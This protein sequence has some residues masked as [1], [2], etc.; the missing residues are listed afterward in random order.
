MSLPAGS[1][2]INWRPD[3]AEEYTATPQPS[4]DA[5]NAFAV[6]LTACADRLCAGVELMVDNGASW[7]LPG[8]RQDDGTTVFTVGAQVTATIQARGLTGTDERTNQ[9]LALAWV[10][11]QL[12]ESTAR[13]AARPAGI[14]WV[15]LAVGGVVVVLVGLAAAWYAQSESRAAIGERTVHAG[16]LAAGAAQAERIRVAQVTGQPIAAPGPVEQAAADS[17]RTAA[18]AAREA[19]IGQA[20]TAVV[21]EAVSGVGKIAMLGIAALFAITLLKSGKD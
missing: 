11:R 12:R 14:G 5:C 10:G 7:M 20:V 18:A 17:I 19:G 15:P 1:P 6:E 16:I 2:A 21:E 13:P 9:I 8:V 3:L 4:A